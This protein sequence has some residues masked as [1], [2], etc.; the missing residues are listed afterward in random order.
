MQ[1]KISKP[2]RKPRG[3]SEYETVVEDR[4]ETETKESKRQQN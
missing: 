1:G 2:L 3:K 4:K